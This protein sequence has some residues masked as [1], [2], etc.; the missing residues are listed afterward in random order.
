MIAEKVKMKDRY[1]FGVI[2]KS[3]AKSVLG[4]RFS[5]N[6]CD[7]SQYSFGL[8]DG[9][10]IV[11]VAVYTSPTGRSVAK[12]I[13]PLLEAGQV[14][15]LSRVWVSSSEQN[16]ARNFFLRKTFDW[17]KNR[18]EVK[19]LV[20]YSD[21]AYGHV[22]TMY[23]ATNWIYQGTKTSKGKSYVYVV[24]NEELHSRTCASKYGSNNA[25]ALRKIDPDY[26]RVEIPKKHRYIYILKDRKGIESTLKFP[27]L[28]F[29]TKEN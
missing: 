9:E 3:I 21:P 24:R 28:P 7:F 14:L 20:G 2:D 11:A 18:T 26:K 8:F 5:S 23:Q 29:P 15:E 22:G 13:S 4:R 10:R 6:P 16:R 1:S 17:L 25:E 12:S 19:C 27:P